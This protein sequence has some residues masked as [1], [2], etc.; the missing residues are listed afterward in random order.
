MYDEENIILM[1]VRAADGRVGVISGVLTFE[2]KDDL[3]AL[4]GSW[5]VPGDEATADDLKGA[6]IVQVL[7][8][9][10]E[11][12]AEDDQTRAKVRETM[13]RELGIEP[14]GDPR[15]E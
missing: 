15:D 6:T 12:I 1:F 14:K 8:Y 10:A 2:E 11:V 5:G 7:D 4:V 13:E 9:N 3:E